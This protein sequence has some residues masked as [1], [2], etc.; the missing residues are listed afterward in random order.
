MRKRRPNTAIDTGSF[1]DISF[2]LMIF[3]MVVT[4]FN[5]N[6]SFEMSLPPP[7]EKSIR[8]GI[9]PKRVVS[10]YINSENKF[11]IN[12]SIY[13]KVDT[14][15]IDKEIIN[16]CSY[17]KPGLI[18]LEMSSGASYDSYLRI[19]SLIKRSKESARQILS[20]RNFSLNY[21]SLASEQKKLIEGLLIFKLVEKE[22]SD[23]TKQEK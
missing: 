22:I 16:I 19:L 1:A 7:E 6:Y 3:F 23:E 8:K 20:E 13:N 15:L 11:L 18:K 9:D 10:I 2:L 12:Q 21:Q 14:T 17:A 5:K 4:T